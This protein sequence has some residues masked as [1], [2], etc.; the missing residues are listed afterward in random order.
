MQV[1]TSSVALVVALQGGI[2]A[3]GLRHDDTLA[4]FYFAI[5]AGICNLFS[6]LVG[7]TAAPEDC[8]DAEMLIF[9]LPK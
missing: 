2:V 6:A 5:V 9:G 1:I 7:D 3:F 4:Q 8:N